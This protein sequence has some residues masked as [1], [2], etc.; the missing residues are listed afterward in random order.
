MPII[1][2]NG[3]YTLFIH[4]PKTGGTSLFQWF[5]TLGNVYFYETNIPSFSKITPQHFTHDN[6]TTLLPFLQFSY[7]FTVVRNPYD[8]FVSEYY[9]RTERQFNRFG[10][11]PSFSQWGLNKIKEFS[12][13]KFIMDNHMRPQSHFVALDIQIF[14]FESGLENIKHE[15]SK[16]LNV[17][18]SQELIHKNK[19]NKNEKVKWSSELRLTFNDLY[20][21]DFSLFSYQLIKP[22]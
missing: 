9:F 2:I 6:I 21:D 18:D 1:D 17:R 13:N 10:K 8:R 19:G 4:I 20:K 11:R 16:T 12:M 15:V 22:I 14:K 5:Q 3:A 7:C